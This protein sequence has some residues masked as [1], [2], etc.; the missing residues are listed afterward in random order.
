MRQRE[1][2]KQ[3]WF[4]EEE[5]K[6]LKDKAYKAGMTES[7]FIRKILLGYQLKEKPD[8]TFYE[9]IKLMRSIS[10][11]INQIAKKAHSLNY[12]DEVAYKKEAA[13]WCELLNNI[14]DKYLINKR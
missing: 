13:R 7:N 10:N 3:F 5:A 14:K 9:V 1:I 11:N 6:I 12:I 4:N 2:K 8:A